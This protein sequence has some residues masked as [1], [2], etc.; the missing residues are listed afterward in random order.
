MSKTEYI[1][2]EQFFSELEGSVISK[3]PVMEG[4][5]TLK[6][7]L[8]LNSTIENIPVFNSD[9]KL[10]SHIVKNFTGKEY[11]IYGIKNGKIQKYEKQSEPDTPP[12]SV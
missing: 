1:S 9:E 8:L 7:A 11:T 12:S 10:A 6:F 2:V 3:K 5:F 4:G